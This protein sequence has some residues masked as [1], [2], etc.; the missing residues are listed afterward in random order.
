MNAETVSEELANMWRT[1]YK[2][3]K[4]FSART[5]P[6]RVT[7]NFKKRLTNSNNTCLFW[8][9]S[10]IQAWRTDT[11]RWYDSSIHNALFISETHSQMFKGTFFD[12]G[13]FNSFEQFMYLVKFCFMTNSFSSQTTV[14]TYWHVNYAGYVFFFWLFIYHY[15][16]ISSLFDGC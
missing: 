14:L 6:A 5:A 4:T 15:C 9:L 13:S 3:A 1:M 12:I 11:G 8:Q 16:C 2:L 7:E 10:A